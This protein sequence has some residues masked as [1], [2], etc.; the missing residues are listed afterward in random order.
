MNQYGQSEKLQLKD[1][2]SDLINC[3]YLKKVLHFNYKKENAMLV[4]R[5]G[6]KLEVDV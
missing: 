6:Y 1:F 4:A 2:A 5:T 3:L